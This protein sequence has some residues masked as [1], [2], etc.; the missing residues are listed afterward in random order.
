M[1]PT[2]DGV[3]KEAVLLFGMFKHFDILLIDIVGVLIDIKAFVLIEI[4]GK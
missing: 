1:I 4:R 2:Y 3:H